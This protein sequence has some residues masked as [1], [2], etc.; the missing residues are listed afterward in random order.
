MRI[1]IF[2]LCCVGV[3]ASVKAENGTVLYN[4]IFKKCKNSLIFKLYY[5]QL[6]HPYTVRV[7]YNYT[8]IINI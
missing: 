8:L 5:T 7:I 2:V 1:D 3:R 4:S 6:F